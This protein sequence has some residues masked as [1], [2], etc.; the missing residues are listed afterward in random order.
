MKRGAVE[1]RGGDRLPDHCDA[2]QGQVLRMSCQLPERPS[3][4]EMRNIEQPAGRE[5]LQI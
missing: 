4:E 5:T 2:L 3:H 1:R